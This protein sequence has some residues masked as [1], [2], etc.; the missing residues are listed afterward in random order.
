MGGI[1]EPETETAAPDT[2]PVTDEPTTEAPT[3]TETTPDTGKPTEDDGTTA[4]PETEAP[5][6]GCGSAMGGMAVL[7]MA[8]FAIM[9]GKKKKD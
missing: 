3:A 8:G 4:E 6:G 9:L 7:I 5:K 1:P 2:E